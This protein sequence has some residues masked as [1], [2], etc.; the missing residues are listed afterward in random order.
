MKA[1]ERGENRRPD[2]EREGREGEAVEASPFSPPLALAVRPNPGFHFRSN[3]RL[4]HSESQSIYF[5]ASVRRSDGRAVRRGT[6]L[7]AVQLNIAT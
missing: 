3:L 7:S 5:T 4:S 2:R 6:K 1:S